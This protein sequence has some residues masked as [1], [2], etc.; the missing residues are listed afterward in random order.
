MSTAKSD[1]PADP[2]TVLYVCTFHNTSVSLQLSSE[3][4]CR[5]AFLAIE[6][7]V[8]SRV[9]RE[10]E[11]RFIQLQRYL[12]LQQKEEMVELRKEVTEGFKL[13]SMNLTCC[14]W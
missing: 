7:R 13:W 9:R 12:E 5:M 4:Q 8:Y 10:Y 2:P 6:G 14:R 11:D 1:H 3:V